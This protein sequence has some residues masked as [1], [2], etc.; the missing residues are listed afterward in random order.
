MAVKK[1]PPTMPLRAAMAKKG[2]KKSAAG[3]PFAPG[4][5][6]ATNADKT[7]PKPGALPLKLAKPRSKGAAK[8]KSLKPSAMK[9]AHTKKKPK[10]IK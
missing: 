4:S 6:G 2:K 5:P 3:S 7:V 10:G 1:K 9:A 8:S